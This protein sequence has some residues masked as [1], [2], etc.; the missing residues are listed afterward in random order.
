MDTMNAIRSILICAIICGLAGT[1]CAAEGTLELTAKVGMDDR[2]FAYRWCP[3]KISIVNTRELVDA[4]ILM[5]VKRGGSIAEYRRPVLL[6]KGY[7]GVIWMNFW[8]DPGAQVS[9]RLVRPGTKKNLAREARPRMRVEYPDRVAAVFGENGDRIRLRG[10]LSGWAVVELE[11]AQDF[12]SNWLGYDALDMLVVTRDDLEELNDWQREALKKWISLG[13][14]FYATGLGRFW[15]AESFLDGLV[16]AI[17]ASD[18]MSQINPALKWK[19]GA[20]AKDKL[21]V[22]AKGNMW[23]AKMTAK[24]DAEVVLMAGDRP[25]IVRRPMGLGWVGFIG[26]N[27]ADANS[28]EKKNVWPRVLC[29]P[30]RSALGM[31]GAGISSSPSGKIEEYLSDVTGRPISRL[32]IVGFML[33]FCVAI[34]PL[35]YIVLRK[36]GKF[37]L[38]LLTFA[39]IVGSFTA[40]AY[41]V[42][43]AGRS[44]DLEFKDITVVDFSPQANM[45]RG[46]C[47]SVALSPEAS[48]FRLETNI[49]DAHI[50]LMGDGGERRSPTI[51]CDDSGYSIEL[52]MKIWTAKQMCTRWVIEDYAPAGEDSIERLARCLVRLGPAHSFRL[53]SRNGYRQ[54]PSGIRNN[55]ADALKPSGTPGIRNI[56]L[57]TL[58]NTLRRELYSANPTGSLRTRLSQLEDSVRYAPFSVADLRYW[59]SLGPA[60]EQGIQTVIRHAEGLPTELSIRRDI[61]RD[62]V[63]LMATLLESPLQLMFDGTP[64]G[65]KSQL[66]R[67]ALLRIDVTDMVDIQQ[68]Q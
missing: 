13:G 7:R 58:Q 24:E 6:G 17:V 43:L 60:D 53:Y 45:L 41:L 15:S 55:L 47:Y 4:E 34:G 38:G 1:V 26:L 12:P 30:P 51:L 40:L 66:D 29:S 37:H 11:K 42:S 10:A 16:P 39:I 44:S 23:F 56:R 67:T 61:E 35:D 63:Y 27:L 68:W 5:E 33:M 64:A 52:P 25:V 62:R 2:A 57:Q 8:C 19:K 54:L 9:V 3:V 18:A 14:E 50:A 48:D 21:L 65:D 36:I 32:W 31:P 49:P 22:E 28:I 20:N 46:T 59:L